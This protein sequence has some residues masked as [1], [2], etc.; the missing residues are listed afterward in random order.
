MPETP[1][2]I[3]ALDGFPLAVRLLVPEGEP[4]KAVVQVN[5]GT[6]PQ[7]ILRVVRAVFS[8]TWLRRVHLGF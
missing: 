2:T 7:G 5:G 8:R 6:H 1:L 4:P 3:P